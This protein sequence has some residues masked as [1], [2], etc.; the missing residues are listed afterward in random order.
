MDT[1]LPPVEHPKSLI[2]KA[3]FYFMR[4]K[5]GKVLKPASV[6]SARMPLGFTSFYGKVNKLDKKLVLP[7]ATVH[8]IRE[9]VATLNQC[10]FCMDATK[11]AALASSDRSAARFD[12]LHAYRTSDLFTDAERAALDYVTEV[13]TDRAVTRATFDAVQR[14]YSEREICDIVWLVA[15][16][17]LY[18][19]NNLALGIGSDNF[20]DMAQSALVE[21]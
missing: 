14:S 21:S 2:W 13:T 12:E 7:E 6:F 10:L 17:H 4:R 3:A 20:C 16:E 5:F 8:V 18:N 9:Q 1:L 19:M 15:S 11:A